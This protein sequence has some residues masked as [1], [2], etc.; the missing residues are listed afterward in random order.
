MSKKKDK[1]LDNLFDNKGL[2]SFC[3]GSD[4]NFGGLGTNGGFGRETSRFT[5]SINDTRKKYNE[6]LDKVDTDTT[7]DML[8]ADIQLG[9]MIYSHNDFDKMLGMSKVKESICNIVDRYEKRENMLL[10]V[11]GALSTALVIVGII[12]RKK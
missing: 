12:K 8:L 11:I 7:E 3:G 2:D 9:N 6:M 4:Y 10:T 5:D 1:K